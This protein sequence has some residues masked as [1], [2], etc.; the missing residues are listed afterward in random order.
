MCVCVCG[1]CVGVWVCVVWSVCGVWSGGVGWGVG[2][3]GVWSGGVCR[4]WSMSGWGLCGWSVVWVECV[5]EVEWVCGV[6]CVYVCVEWVE[7]V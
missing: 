6:E 3:C 7:Y 5:C 2:V 4:V 1:V